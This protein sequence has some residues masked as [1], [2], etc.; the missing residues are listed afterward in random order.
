MSPMTGRVLCSP[1]FVTCISVSECYSGDCTPS[2]EKTGGEVGWLKTPAG[3]I[4]AVL[5]IYTTF[6]KFMAPL[7]G[8]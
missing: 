3:L 4:S 2:Y 1:G 5:L 7:A 6:L 8:L